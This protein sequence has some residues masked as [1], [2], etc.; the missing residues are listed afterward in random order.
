MSLFVTGT[1]TDVGK[2]YVTR[3]ILQGLREQGVDAVGFKPISCGGLEDSEILAEAS[4]GLPVDVVNPVQLQNA[5]AP[6]VAC[7]LENRE[8]DPQQLV[9]AYHQL[10]AKHEVV[11]IEGA[12]GWEVPIS[13][14]YRISDLARDIGLPVLLVTGNQLG[15]INHT[16]LSVA[17]I[18]S[19]GL[20]CK[21]IVLNQLVDELDTAMITNKGILEE[22]SGV[23]LLDHLIHGQDF[24]D[25]E[26][27]ACAKG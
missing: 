25:D 3:L 8:I 26:V 6:H 15:A 17:A 24:I 5:V 20:D 22:L 10:A 13:A 12:G 9:E 7:M 19:K 27:L 4:G 14:D 11:L 18:Q 2:T 23:P 21:G 1:N 16:L